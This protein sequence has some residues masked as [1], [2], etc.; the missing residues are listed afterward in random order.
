VV[1]EDRAAALAEQVRAWAG[2]A[3]A[4]V[5]VSRARNQGATVSENRDSTNDG[6]GQGEVEATPFPPPP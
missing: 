3:G 1:E 5:W 4:E 2:P 6:G